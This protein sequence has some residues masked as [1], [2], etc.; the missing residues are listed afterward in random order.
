MRKL[1]WTSRK[2]IGC[3]VIYDVFVDPGEKASII[4]D[5]HDLLL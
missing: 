1:D 3:R 4:G 5:A 2:N